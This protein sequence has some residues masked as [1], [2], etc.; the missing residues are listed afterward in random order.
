M[1]H[2]IVVS[3]TNWSGYFQASYAAL[4]TPH[5][6]PPTHDSR[7]PVNFLTRRLIKKDFS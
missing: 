3:L 7:Y 1:R 6:G 4:L 5:T 2:I